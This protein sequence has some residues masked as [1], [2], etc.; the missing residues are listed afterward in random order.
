MC[1]R[2]DSEYLLDILAC[3]R[4]SRYIHDISYED[5]ISNEEKQDAVIH[6]IE[7]KVVKRSS[8]DIKCRVE[9]IAG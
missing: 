1:R 7:V 2:G 3:R 4:I 9:E 6:S 8:D 5:F